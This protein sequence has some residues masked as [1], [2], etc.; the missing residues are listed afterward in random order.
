[1]EI[2]KNSRIDPA[3]LHGHRLVFLEMDSDEPPTSE[4]LEPPP[5]R[6][7]WRGL[8]KKAFGQK[9]LGENDPRE[10]LEEEHKRTADAQ[11]IA[12]AKAEIQKLRNDPARLKP[13]NKVLQYLWRTVR[14]NARSVWESLGKGFEESIHPKKHP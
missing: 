2:K 3:D 4:T 13:G 6:P 10:R 12:A 5:D 14:T 7:L 1:M 11:E 9:Y 8:L